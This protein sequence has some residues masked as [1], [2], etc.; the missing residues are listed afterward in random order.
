MFLVRSLKI[1]RSLHEQSSW[2]RIPGN[3]CFESNLMQVFFATLHLPTTCWTHSN[4]VKLSGHLKNTIV[5]QGFVQN[6]LT[7]NCTNKKLDGLPWMNLD[8]WFLCGNKR[9]CCLGLLGNPHIKSCIHPLA[10]CRYQI[11][12][13]SL[14]RTW[15]FI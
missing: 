14:P 9:S 7:I 4:V 6:M 3:T 12:N 8:S 11:I 2:V 1:S 10:S 5:R 13:C 15:R